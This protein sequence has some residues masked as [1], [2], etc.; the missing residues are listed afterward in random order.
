MSY[1]RPIEKCVAWVFTHER[2]LDWKEGSTSMNE[3]NPNDFRKHSQKGSKGSSRAF[4]KK[5]F[6]FFS[7]ERPSEPPMDLPFSIG[8]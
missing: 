4:W 3:V 8:G 6:F 7:F 2:E 5:G 1:L